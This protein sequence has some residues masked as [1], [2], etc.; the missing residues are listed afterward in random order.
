MNT[1]PKRPLTGLSFTEL[2]KALKATEVAT[3]KDSH[4]A[5]CLRKAITK[6]RRA[7]KRRALR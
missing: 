2:C 1:H 4:S 7:G 6:K 5:Q 3:G